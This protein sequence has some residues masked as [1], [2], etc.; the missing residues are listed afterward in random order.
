ML[1]DRAANGAERT[2]PSPT[3]SERFI[4]V[5]DFARIARLSRRTIDRYRR[6]RPVGFPKEY[7]LSRGRVPRPRF[8]LAEV[9]AWME[10]RALW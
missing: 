4:T 6:D 8:K 3:P 10:T 7:D 1:G 5:E 9:L 2:C